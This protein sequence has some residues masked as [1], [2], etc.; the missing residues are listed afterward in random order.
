M[1]NSPIYPEP[2]FTNTYKK[3]QNSYNSYD[4]SFTESNNT[5]GSLL[6]NI[7]LDQIKKFLP[8]LLHKKDKNNF[9]ILDLIK[10]FSPDAEKLFSTISALGLNGKKNNNIKSDDTS[11]E[12][13]SIIDISGYEETS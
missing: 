13:E 1:N 8:I 12:P 5:L 7:N 6:K 4:N 9:N 2:F 3:Q 10:S 11:S